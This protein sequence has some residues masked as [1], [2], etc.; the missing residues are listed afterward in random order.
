MF[1]DDLIEQ[2]NTKETQAQYTTITQ[3]LASLYLSGIIKLQRERL[4]S[5]LAGGFDGTDDELLAKVK[6]HRFQDRQLASLEQLGGHYANSG[7]E[8][9]EP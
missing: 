6:T 1:D 8:V 2:F 7:T 3:A 4:L 9:N 5:Q